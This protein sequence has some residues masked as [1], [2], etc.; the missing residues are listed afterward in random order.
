MGMSSLQS[1]LDHK[2]EEV[3]KSIS[4]TV[5]LDGFGFGNVKVLLSYNISDDDLLEEDS[6]GEI[7]LEDGGHLIQNFKETITDGNGFFQF[8]D[9]MNGTYILTAEK[10]NYTFAPTERTV[11]VLDD[12]HPNQDF[13]AYQTTSDITGNFYTE[14]P[15][16]SGNF[17]I[18]SNQRIELKQRT[19]TLTFEIFNHT[20]D[21]IGYSSLTFFG[22][23][24]ILTPKT[25]STT[26]LWLE[27]FNILDNGMLSNLG[28]KLGQGTFK[29]SVFDGRYLWLLPNTNQKYINR[30]D[31][32]Y[33]LPIVSYPHFQTNNFSWWQCGCIENDNLWMFPGQS[34][35]NIIRL[36]KTTGIISEFLY[37]TDPDVPSGATYFKSAI[38]DSINN[39]IWAS[40]GT[41]ANFCRIDCTTGAITQ[42]PYIIY[43]TEIKS[44]YA[45]L[46]LI[47]D[48][49]YA[50]PDFA[51]YI[52]RIHRTTNVLEHL[53]FNTTGF[54]YPNN[55]FT[56]GAYD[57][58]G[59]IWLAPS[60]APVIAKVNINTW[61]YEYISYDYNPSR[62][63]ETVPGGGAT[64]GYSNG[65]FDKN[66]FV[67]FAPRGDPFIM[68]VNINTNTV[69]QIAYGL[70][71]QEAKFSQIYISPIGDSLYL[72]PGAVDDYNELQSSKIVKIN[73]FE[74]IDA[75]LTEND[76]PKQYRFNSVPMG[77]YKLVIWP[78]WNKVQLNN[79]LLPL[80]ADVTIVDSDIVQD[81]YA[82]DPNVVIVGNIT[83]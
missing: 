8:T 24:F 14:W 32:I 12:N 27:T 16:G 43:G 73:I 21:P 17:D 62:W 36:N 46:L 75:Q 59:Y 38:Y 31:T 7:L 51:P 30:V 1:R 9:V 70:S 78:N 60:L 55:P 3:F 41:T 13:V 42:I 19:D 35:L 49:L 23:Q 34:N 28:H 6:S 40:P 11:I 66:Q 65:V 68:R 50:L 76:P 69:E 56:G 71:G 22:N 5:T 64:G 45:S 81:F 52:I 72:I 20:Q 83:D 4:G 25:N 26:L 37:P 44:Q 67:Y 57:E 53:Q 29:D 10:N 33:Y 80:F 77:N 74:T 15:A 63:T 48:Y 18:N 39:C 47:G 2:T 61:T 79:P 58:N 54:D 82:L